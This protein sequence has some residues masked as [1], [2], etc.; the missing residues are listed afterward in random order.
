MYVYQYYNILMDIYK[1]FVQIPIQK[2]CGH[3]Y[4][5]YYFQNKLFGIHVNIFVSDCQCNI[6]WTIIIFHV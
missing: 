4:L 3:V 2:T 1:Y 6:V 5:F